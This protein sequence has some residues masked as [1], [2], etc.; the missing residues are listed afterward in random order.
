M[1]MRAWL[2]RG[3]RVHLLADSYA[4]GLELVAGEVLEIRV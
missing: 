4:F 1:T 2:P 3:R